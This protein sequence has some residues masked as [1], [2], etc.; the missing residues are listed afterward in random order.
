MSPRA[1]L[2]GIMG[3]PG[4]GKSTLARTLAERL[5]ATLY[6]EPEEQAWPDHVRTQFTDGG[7]AAEAFLYFRSVRVQQ[8]VAAQRDAIAGRIAIVDSYYDKLLCDYIDHPRMQ[9]FLGHGDPAFPD[10]QRTA[11]LDYDLLPDVDVLIFIE[12]TP[13]RW[14]VHLQKRGRGMD[15]QNDFQA[16]FEIQTRMRVAA[17]RFTRERRARLIDVR[18]D[19]GSEPDIDDLIGKLAGVYEPS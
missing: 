11:I 17:E 8:L 15:S 9:W 13:A 12:I 4:A 10:I 2:V 7:Y 3:I 19:L 1:P 18:Y 6:C 16:S 5:G 14:K